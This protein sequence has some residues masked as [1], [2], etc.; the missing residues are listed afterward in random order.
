[1]AFLRVKKKKGNNYYYI[2]E[3]YRIDGKVKQRILEYIGPASNLSDYALKGW[4]SVHQPDGTSDITFKS[5]THGSVIALYDMASLVGIE[6]ILDRHFPPKTVKGLKRS[7]VLLL[8]MIHRAVDPGSKRSF[9]AWAGSTSLPYHLGFKADDIDSAAFWEAMD[10]I[11]AEQIKDAHRE[12]VDRVCAMTGADLKSFHLDYTNYYTFIDSKN[13]RCVICK[14]G[15]NKQK[16][17]DLRQFSLAVLTSFVLQVPLVWELYEGNKNDKAEFPDFV[18]LVNEEL[19]AHGMNPSEVTISF[20]GGSNSEENFTGLP[21]HFI[22]AHSLT[23]H[24][25]LYDID[26]DEYVPVDIGEGNMRKAYRIDNMVFSGITGTGILTYSRALEDGQRSQ[27]EK[28]LAGL[29][30][31]CMEMNEKLH[32]ARS[33]IYTELARKKEQVEVKNRQ[34]EEYNRKIDEEPPRKGKRKKK[35]ELIIWDETAEL[36]SIIKD[37]AYRGWRY[38]E[39]F[40]DIT[41]DAYGNAICTVDEAGKE[42]YI[43]KYYGKKLTCTD[44]TDWSTEEILAEYCEQ[45]CIE[46]SIFR[47][48][49]DKDH[50]SVRPQYHWTDDKIRMHTF[51]CLGAMV[52]TEM[53]RLRYEDAGIHNSRAMMIDLLS[54]IHDGWIIR[55]G[56]KVKRAIEDMGSNQKKLWAVVEELESELKNKV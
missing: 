37:K 9:A 3:N 11:S 10:G 7:R 21:F 13:G 6:D 18:K 36:L 33:R 28:D 24:R 45:E 55:D 39:E 16:R 51:I 23:G 30:V 27:L 50:I 41:I 29:K 53:L 1:M 48:S 34:I 38:L 31:S 22:C 42:A 49:K 4:L 43:R 5:Y 20:D 17:D 35:K 12:I 54:G 19:L 47:V 32:N 52:I 15:H 44:H 46:N 56:K 8:A 2:V 40:T 26:L 25:E 14:R